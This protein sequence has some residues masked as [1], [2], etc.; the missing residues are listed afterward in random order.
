MVD[1]EQCAL[2]SFEDH[3][4]IGLERLVDQRRRV[5][6]E[7]LEPLAVK[8]VLLGDRLQVERRVALELPQ[9]QPLWLQRSHD[10]LLEDLLVK[11]VLNANTEPQCL[12]GVTRADAAPRSS[13][14]KLAEPR[15]AGLIKHQV[16]GHD[17]VCV[18]AEAEVAYVNATFA[19]PVELPGQYTRVDDNA[20]ADHAECVGVEDPRWDQVELPDVVAV[21][22]CVAG[23]VAALEAGNDLR[24]LRQKI[25][26]LPFSFI[27]PLG[28]DYN[29]PWHQR[30][31]L[32]GARPDVGLASV[33]GPYRAC[34]RPRI[35]AGLRRTAGRV[36]TSLQASKQS[37][38]RSAR[39][40]RRAR[41]WL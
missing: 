26:D 23:I 7:L 28:A 31:S 14:L 5:G 21:D 11:H 41:D 34:Q 39:Q 20:V 27:A 4:P 12:V 15:L 30:R 17:Q 9:L 40:A 22:N 33:A 32:R 8:Q 16:V 13:D 6:D 18:G 38:R 2:R 1:I 25:D 24:T 3:E 35:G 29:D 36:R 10:L 19:Q 37:A